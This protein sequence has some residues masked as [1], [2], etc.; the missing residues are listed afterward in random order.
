MLKERKSLK[1][2]RMDLDIFFRRTL[3]ENVLEYVKNISAWSE[4]NKE[5]V[6]AY[7]YPEDMYRYFSRLSY[8]NLSREEIS[9]RY[10]ILFNRENGLNSIFELLSKYADEVLDSRNGVPVCKVNRIL[11][12]NEASNLLGQ[13]IFI[14]AWYAKKFS[15]RYTENRH[16]LMFSW[17]AIIRADEPRIQSLFEKGL[18]ENHFHL[19]GATQSFALSWACLMN[20]PDT[21]A[22]YFKSNFGKD[23]SINMQPIYG[24]DI[25]P[26]TD[27]IKYAA[28]IRANLFQLCIEYDARDVK[29]EL[30]N[31][32]NIEDYHP[33]DSVQIICNITESL[34]YQYGY[35]FKQPDECF[36]CLDYAIA[37]VLYRVDENSPVRLLT[38][39]R[40]FMYQCFKNIFN[41]KFSQIQ[42]N[43]FYVYLLIKSGFRGE[44]IQNN[45]M[46]GFANFQEYQNRKNQFF[47]KR[48]EYWTESLRLSVAMAL[49]EG[50][51]YSLE[52]RIMP[53]K[54]A[55]ELEYNIR[56]IDMR[57]EYALNNRETLKDFFYV[58]HFPKMP[59][60]AKEY[61]DLSYEVPRNYK[62]RIKSRQFA[63]ALG[64]YIENEK[65]SEQ[66]I[67]G[68][69]ACSTEIGCRPEV[70]ATE[71][72]YIRKC[73]SRK[74]EECEIRKFTTETSEGKRHKEFGITYHVGEDFLDIVDGLRAI[75]EAI[76]FLEMRKGDRL[77]HAI[78][79]GIDPGH[80]YKMK[81]S[82][83][84]LTKQDILDNL[85]WVLYRSQE[86][87]ISIIPDLRIELEGRARKLLYEIYACNVEFRVS[88]DDYY[89]SWKMRGDNPQLYE[90][91][92][93]EA[94]KKSFI[95]NVYD[96]CKI[97]S[98]EKIELFRNN[99]NAS[100]LFYMYHFNPKVKDIGLESERFAI[101]SD[102]VE[103]VR[104]IQHRMQL[105]VNQKGIAIEC[106][107]TSNLRISVI[108]SYDKHPIFNLNSEYLEEECTNI[109]MF[110]SI[111]TDDI[112]VF[113]TSLEN[114][115][116]VIYDAICQKRH[117][118]GNYDD[119]QVIRYLDHIRQNGLEMAFKKENLHFT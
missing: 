36:R 98:E 89:D 96:E 78:A 86:L 68:I 62:V 45:G 101:T 73:S 52:G 92:F 20:F 46:V 102:I 58:I 109:H 32:N 22:Q 105:Y 12:W 108:D 13:D 18:A 49:D 16:P 93:Y 77:G 65:T 74:A 15:E 94:C 112:G 4:C 107:P 31:K 64:Q 29:N 35:K 11:S 90:K 6:N 23:L 87:G 33:G 9:N 103:M 114:E 24:L 67:F 85:V 60:D 1:K 70:F 21:I 34:R 116:M 53:K 82:E 59:F 25:L 10:R 66:R 79:L 104:Q 57:I 50:H 81:H 72:R 40:N 41:G 39:E 51:I 119:Y 76:M 44:M 37:P 8:A 17:K 54:S 117:E 118:A 100:F 95:D 111:N 43:Y 83:V 26:W 7:T 3:P 84:F 56:D 38:G 63:I 91:G 27:R 75:D 99:K 69:D 106:N 55:K 28:W 110:V 14:T 71:F 113:D 30:L 5:L 47:E 2:E 88:L 115:Y 97:L 42:G 48:I 61:R 80:Y 19:H